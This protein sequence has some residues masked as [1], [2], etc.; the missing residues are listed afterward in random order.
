MSKLFNMTNDEIQDLHEKSR[1]I[2]FESEN[3]LSQK[4]Y[5]DL[6]EFVDNLE[7]LVSFYE[8]LILD[9]GQLLDYN[10]LK[11]LGNDCE[12]LRE[13][14]RKDLE[15]LNKVDYYY[16]NNHEKRNYMFGYP[17]NMEKDSYI[18]RYL[19]FLESKLYLMN[20]CGDPYE[21]GNYDMDSKETER[22]II[23][24][25]AESFGISEGEYWGY[26][27]SGG[28]ES[29]FWA[30]REGFNRFPEGRL[31]FSDN[32][33]YSV[34]KF[35]YN[36]KKG[37]IYPYTVVKSNS[38]GS[39]C[40]QDFIDK[41]ADDR[42]KFG[43]KPV[44][45]LLTWGTTK[46]GAID[47]VKEITDYLTQNKIEFYCH[48]D[49][50][51]FGGI[52]GNQNS[53]PTVNN[54]KELSVDSISVSLHKYLGASRAN[55]V[56]IALSKDKRKVIDYIG[57]EDSTLLGSRDFPPFSTLQ[58]VKEFL[59]LKESG[60]YRKN[61]DYFKLRMEE[62]GIK[63]SLFS[64]ECNIFVIDKPSD[65][66]C[67][68]YQLATF[69]QGEIQKAHIIIFPFHEKRYMDELIEDLAKETV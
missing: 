33:H 41:L 18:L 7:G 54:L 13:I 9:F 12:R 49:A 34:E 56:L 50:A 11:K 52:S 43:Y 17:S 24:A 47:A 23:T 31:Y 53:A 64:N 39:I 69:S 27:T 2:L 5:E 30:I 1:R 35:V 61:I 3:T 29:N 45:V 40:V 14:R 68:K 42:K 25:F 57:Q 37:M 10:E 6:K 21:R 32:T 55:G 8:G 15:Y 19:R 22:E 16:H 63:Y 38:D 58:R 65:A 59:T 4:E 26:V 51:L 67:E 20:N 36:D 28:T 66:I 44:I 62:K 46:E 48:L 60:H